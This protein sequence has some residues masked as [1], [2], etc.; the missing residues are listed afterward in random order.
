M[1]L[2]ALLCDTFLGPFEGNLTTKHVSQAPGAR[3]DVNN[4]VGIRWNW[5]RYNT[6]VMIASAIRRQRFTQCMCFCWICDGL[7]SSTLSSLDR[8]ELQ[9]IISAH[10]NATKSVTTVFQHQSLPC[11]KR[12]RHE[13]CHQRVFDARTTA[14]VLT[15]HW[16]IDQRR[17]DRSRCPIPRSFLACRFGTDITQQHINAGNHTTSH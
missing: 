13:L 7:E 14:D 10:S 1:L 3:Q 15:C 2:T 11:D 8:V 9:H 12:L 16:Q 5:Q 17:A 4:D 6:A